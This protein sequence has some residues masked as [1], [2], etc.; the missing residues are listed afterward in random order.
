M[1]KIYLYN[2]LEESNINDNGVY[3]KGYGCHWDEP[4]L[5]FFCCSAKSL[6][7]SINEINS[8]KAT[9]PRFNYEHNPAELVGKWEVV[10]SDSTGLYLEGFLPYSIVKNRDY[11]IPLIK[12]GIVNTLSTEIYAVEGYIGKDNVAYLVDGDLVGISLVS[13]PADPDAT[14]ELNSKI[15]KKD[16]PT[17]KPLSYWYGV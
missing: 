7:R 8:G 10:K 6:E 13:I 12:E 5:N 1:N 17:V 14:F 9:M 15:W 2:S 11:I 3:I 4:N 16:E